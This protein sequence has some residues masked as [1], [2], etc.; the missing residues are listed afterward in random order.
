[1][2]LMK[3]KYLPADAVGTMFCRN[4]STT[5]CAVDVGTPLSRRKREHMNCCNVGLRIFNFSNNLF[6]FPLV[7]K[8]EHFCPNGLHGGTHLEL[9][10]LSMRV[11]CFLRL[12][13]YFIMQNVRKYASIFLFTIII[14][15]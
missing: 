7:L 12:S 4:L 14:W 6:A 8:L 15:K 3:P 9:R 5:L 11:L 10:K 1:M 13:H 2:S